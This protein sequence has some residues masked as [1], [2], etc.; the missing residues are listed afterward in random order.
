[1]KNK[2][3]T[4]REFLGK[5]TAGLAVAGV[6]AHNVTTASGSP[7]GNNAPSVGGNP[8]ALALKGGTAVRTTPFPTWPQA[9]QIDEDYVLKAVRNQKWCSYDGEFGPKFEKAFA[10]YV[11]TTGAVMTTGGTHT[12]NMSLELLGIGPG[13]E[14]L[15][16]PMTAVAT[17]CSVFMT[18]A[19]PVFVDNEL[20]AEV[21]EARTGVFKGI[22]YPDYP[23][24]SKNSIGGM[25]K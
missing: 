18:Y 9:F 14:V 19:L 16:S 4:R 6:A 3:L 12:L 7:A 8:N 5:T 15:L 25:I 11:G 17:A 22:V 13:D 1:M 10:Q 21:R 2:A 20:I 23:H 24:R